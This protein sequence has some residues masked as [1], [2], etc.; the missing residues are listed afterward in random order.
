MAA[1][2]PASR[3]K[4]AAT[5]GAVV[6]KAVRAKKPANQPAKN[7]SAEKFD[8]FVVINGVEYGLKPSLDEESIAHVGAAI[9]DRLG[10][11]DGGRAIGRLVSSMFLPGE[12][13]RYVQECLTQGEKPSFEVIFSSIVDVLEE[14]T[15]VPSA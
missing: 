6:R 12:Y 11:E 14:E 2:T 15:G 13:A 1:T 5:G 9:D 7:G 3:R 10:T 8:L 4:P